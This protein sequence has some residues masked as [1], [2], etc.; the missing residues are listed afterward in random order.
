MC[1]KDN[2]DRNRVQLARFVLLPTSFP[3]LEFN[4][5]VVIQTILNKLIH[6]VAHDNNFIS[7][8]TKR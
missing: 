3:K 6:K 5:G 7:E 2:F 8:T 1:F 4:K